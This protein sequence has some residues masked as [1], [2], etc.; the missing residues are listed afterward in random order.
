MRGCLIHLERAISQELLLPYSIAFKNTLV[1]AALSQK[2]FEAILDGK[3][4]L[5]VTCSLNTIKALK[6]LSVEVRFV[7][8]LTH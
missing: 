7:Q 3:Q 1:Q 6:I 5:M 4:K 2:H 8:E